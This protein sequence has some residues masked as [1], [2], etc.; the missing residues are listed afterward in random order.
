MS[1]SIGFPHDSRP[2]TPSHCAIVAH[3][4]GSVAAGRAAAGA[5]GASD[6]IASHR[7]F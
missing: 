4:S 2:G 3:T 7:R 6:R 5:T 1:D